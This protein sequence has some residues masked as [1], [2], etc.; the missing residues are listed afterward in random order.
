MKEAGLLS[1]NRLVDEAVDFLVAFGTMQF[2]L[3]SLTKPHGGVEY[4]IYVK[5]ESADKKGR[6]T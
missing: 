4:N 1:G 2:Y 6:R 3:L 5:Q